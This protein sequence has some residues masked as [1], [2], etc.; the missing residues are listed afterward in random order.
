MREM[1]LQ[2]K[3]LL[4]CYFHECFD[5]NLFQNRDIWAT[6]GGNGSVSFTTLINPSRSMRSDTSD[7]LFKIPESL[8]S[9]S[10]KDFKL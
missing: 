5:S 1:I 2:R 6:C 10:S 8:F 9:K 7:V 4:K 3:S